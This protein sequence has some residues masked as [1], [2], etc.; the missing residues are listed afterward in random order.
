MGNFFASKLFRLFST[1]FFFVLQSAAA[2]AKHSGYLKQKQIS[3]ALNLY[4]QSI[5]VT[6]EAREFLFDGYQDALID[7][8]QEFQSMGVKDVNIPYDRF[9]WFYT[10]S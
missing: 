7:M 2:T 9:G 8:A 4:Q 5:Y 1:N 10:V 6:K 3:L